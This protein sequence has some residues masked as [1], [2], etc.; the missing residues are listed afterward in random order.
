MT[1]HLGAKAASSGYRLS[2]YDSIGS[3]SVEAME[4]ARAGDPG[5]LWVASVEQTSGH[6]RR[7]RA[8]QTQRGNLAASC[9]MLLPT[10]G[11]HVATLGFVASLALHEALVS[12]LPESSLALGL[13]GAEAEQGERARLEV[14]WPNDLLADG[15]K[16]A[17]LLIESEALPDGSHAVVAGIGVNVRHPP[18]DVPYPATA[19]TRIAPDITAETLFAQLSE[20]WI[21]YVAAWERGGFASIRGAWLSRAAGLGEPV[22]VRTDA[23]VQKG[24]FETI[25][26]TGRLVIRTA[27]G[28]SATVTAG[29]VHFGVAAS[30]REPQ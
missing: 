3:T 17:G 8:W 30:V 5:H 10:G 26:E 28:R 6:G 2:S 23:G 29:D 14:K 12:L 27:D 21:D 1:F 25:D 4:R 13:D 24:V 7:G 22:A 15:A 18:D 11:A 16:I 19:L 9:L 20:T